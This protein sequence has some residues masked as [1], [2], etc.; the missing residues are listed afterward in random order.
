MIEALEEEDFDA[1]GELAMEDMDEECDVVQ[2]CLPKEHEDKLAGAV[3]AIQAMVNRPLLL[4][5]SQ[6]EWLEQAIRVYNGRP[7]VKTD[8]PET[9]AL[10]R[11]YGAQM[12][13]T[14]NGNLIFE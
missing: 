6:T 7:A 3:Q 14:E 5:A 11:R 8:S 10:C 13:K 1:L 2:V 4:C 9:E 12:A